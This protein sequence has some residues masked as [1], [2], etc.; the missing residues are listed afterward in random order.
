MSS[1]TDENWALPSFPSVPSLDDMNALNE[2]VMSGL[3]EALVA[4][5]EAL[6][7]FDE[8]L[9]DLGSAS[10]NRKTKRQLGSSK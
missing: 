6:S 1:S 5:N 3:N 10:D 7:E 4:L 8:A 2:K 9:S